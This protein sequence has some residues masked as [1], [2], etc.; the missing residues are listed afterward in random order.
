M[1]CQTILE[2][3]TGG[4]LLLGTWQGV[5][6]WEHRAAARHRQVVAAVPG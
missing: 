1:P 3:G 5:F 6:P 2:I 4:R